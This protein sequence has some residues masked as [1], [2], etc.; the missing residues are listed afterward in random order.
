MCSMCGYEGQATNLVPSTTM[1]AAPQQSALDPS[2]ELQAAET[3]SNHGDNSIDHS[4]TSG[5]AV[6]EE[7]KSARE[8]SGGKMNGECGK[9]NGKGKK[10][11]GAKGKGGKGASE[12]QPA[13]E[14]ELSRGIQNSSGDGSSDLSS[15]C[16][17]KK[18]KGAKGKGAPKGKGTK[19]SPKEQPLEEEEPLQEVP[20]PNEPE[21]I[22][23]VPIPIEPEA[24]TTSEVLGLQHNNEEEFPSIQSL[25]AQRGKG[26][27]R[28]IEWTCTV[29]T[30][31]H[32]EL[33]EACEMC[34]TPRPP[35]QLGDPIARPAVPAKS[36][37]QA[38]QKVR[39]KPADSAQVNASTATKGAS[40]QDISPEDDAALILQKNS[41]IISNVK[42]VR[43]VLEKE[44]LLEL[45]TL[46]L[47]TA[48][49]F[50]EIGLSVSD[51]NALVDAVQ[52]E[53][54][55]RDLKQPHEDLEVL[56]ATTGAGN[57]KGGSKDG[58]EADTRMRNDIST[59]M[60]LL[61]SDAGLDQQ[62]VECASCLPFQLHTATFIFLRKCL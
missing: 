45:D 25:N 46:V 56:Q 4:S 41:D 17:G 50:K 22:V 43:K 20:T 34:C 36:F 12:Q 51:S 21:V 55:V 31:T 3:H 5:G 24:L 33:L 61:P 40:S 42:N 26:S 35:E 8:K 29:C 11:K 39:R 47:M 19:G 38:P 49:D 16:K 44:Q 14:D 1:P 15:S 48:A 53:L 57:A 62:H 10:A 59:L 32:A 18:G 9:P 60:E 6:A 28:L 2:Q 13:K 37:K 52:E 23:E 30:F 54:K 27:A 58:D 7:A